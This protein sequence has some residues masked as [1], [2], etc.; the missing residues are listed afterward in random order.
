MYIQQLWTIQPMS[1]KIDLCWGSQHPTMFRETQ[2][3]NTNAKKLRKQAQRREIV[4]G[5]RTGEVEVRDE[6]DK[7]MTILGN[8][9]RRNE[10]K[11]P[12]GQL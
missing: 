6:N 11:T 8:G 1:Q 2:I 4:N 3:Y 5:V 12:T 9:K 7:T 10:K